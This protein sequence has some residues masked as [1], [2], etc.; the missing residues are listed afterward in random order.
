MVL[1]L[2]LAP[3]VAEAS[4]PPTLIGRQNLQKMADS[5]LSLMGYTLTPDVTTGSLSINSDPTSNPD[6]YSSS[7]GG[8]FTFS[9][10]TPLYLEGTLGVNRYDPVFLVSDGTD[11]REL[12]TKWNSL[13][14]TLGAG[15]DFF[16]TDE[17][18]LRPIANLTLGRV[19]T[20]G[21]VAGFIVEELTGTELEF[22]DGGKREVYGLGGTLMLDWE[23]YRKDYEIDVELRYTDIHLKSLSES[24]YG[25]EGN[26]D[27]QSLSLW[28]RWRAPSGLTLFDRPFRYV[29][30][31]AHTTFLADLEGQLGF[32]ALNSIGAG[33]EF[34]SSAYDLIITRTRLVFRY[35]FGSNVEGSSVGIAVSF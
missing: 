14:G 31:A 15:W 30:E 13:A 23:H 22:L 16:L 4:P 21:S 32:D 8:G 20:D 25:V 34:D 19:V 3:I 12:P 26:S 1:V 27:A 33:I 28:S 6:I 2:A 10:D 35:Q 9:N 5:I 17:L 7:V 24:S 18:R 29:L 11:Q